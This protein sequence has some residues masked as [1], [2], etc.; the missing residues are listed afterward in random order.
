M[1]RLLPALLLLVQAVISVRTELVAVP[2]SVTDGRGRHVSGLTQDNFR[3]Y[4]DGR[5][6]P[7][8]L[9]HHGNVPVTLGV[10]VDRSGS[11]RAKGAALM[12]AVSALLASSRPDDEL[13]GADFSDDVTLALPGDDAFTNDSQALTTALAAVPADGRTALYDGVAEGLRHLELGHAQRKALVVV[14]DGGDNASRHTYAQVLALARRSEAVIYAIGL[15]STVGGEED[16]DAR[17]LERL[18]KDTPAARRIFRGRMK[19]WR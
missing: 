19:R 13:F 12:V 5:P 7:I 15:T 2:V 16:G 18:C 14:S 9:F 4:E 6:Q 1:I 3:V 17:L 8:T 10:I 11:V